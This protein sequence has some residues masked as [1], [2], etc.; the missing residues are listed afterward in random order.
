MTQLMLV[1]CPVAADLQ[2]RRMTGAGRVDRLEAG[3]QLE[4]VLLGVDRFVRVLPGH[5][6]P[7]DRMAI[8]LHF[9]R[10]V[11]VHQVLVPERVLWLLAVM[12]PDPLRAELV[13]VRLV[14]DRPERNG[15]DDVAVVGGERPYRV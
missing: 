1:P 15:A 5:V 4:A 3:R 9:R 14:A 12:N 7:N 10:R 13:L 8:P 6:S 2:H 11:V